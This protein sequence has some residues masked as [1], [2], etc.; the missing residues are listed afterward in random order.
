MKVIYRCLILAGLFA[1]LPAL[2][3]GEGGGVPGP[4]SQAIQLFSDSEDV[5]AAV[6]K[7]VADGYAD[8]SQGANMPDIITVDGKCYADPA[9]GSFQ[10]CNKTYLVTRY[11]QKNDAESHTVAGIVTMDATQKP[12][13]HFTFVE[14]GKFKDALKSFIKAP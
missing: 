12:M 8:Q 3:G 14:E 6:K 1:S 9:T 4:R 5:Q 7:W 2:A 10:M 11:F 13:F